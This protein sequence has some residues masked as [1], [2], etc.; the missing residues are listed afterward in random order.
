[1]GPAMRPPDHDRVDDAALRRES[2]GRSV[3]EVAHARREAEHRQHA[4]RSEP[5]AE[6]LVA[7][8]LLR[9]RVDLVD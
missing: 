2:I 3:E 6:L 9:D 8:G 4:P 5:F 1:M 7:G